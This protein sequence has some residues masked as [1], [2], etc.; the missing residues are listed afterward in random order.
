M[1]A[2]V[3]ML[4]GKGKTCEITLPTSWLQPLEDHVEGGLIPILH[5][6]LAIPHMVAA[7]SS[8]GS[9]AGGSTSA[10]NGSWFGGLLSP[11]SGSSSSSGVVASS[12]ALQAAC[13]SLPPGAGDAA[14]ALLGRSPSSP[15]AAP[16]AASAAASHREC[17]RLRR[18]I[19]VHWRQVGCGW[20]K[21]TATGK[22]L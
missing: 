6:A 12:P 14:L 19:Q 15:S 11:G 17:A 3:V 8:Q 10:S 9:N 5:A 18:D 1:D 22:Q 21:M 20:L 13:A 2:D 4:L 7:A 16:S